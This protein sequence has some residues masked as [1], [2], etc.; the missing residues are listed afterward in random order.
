VPVSA[1]PPVPLPAQT[2][3]R[4]DSIPTF[5]RP[6]GSLLRPGTSTYQLTLTRPTGEA[7]SL[8]TLAVTVSEAQAGAMTGWLIADSRVGTLISTSDSVF[9]RRADLA[10]ERWTAVNG[11]AQLGVSFT[12]DSAFGALQNYQ[13]R[14]SFALGV[15]TNALLSTGMVQRVLELLPLAEGYRAGASLFV[16]E[17]LVPKLVPA[18][19]LVERSEGVPVGG[20]AEDA[21]RVVLRWGE[22]ERRLWIAR[23]GA[24]VVRTEQAV[25]EGVLTGVL[26]P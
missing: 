25:P 19:I 3:L 18:E 17:G 8:G 12:R 13:G 23:N 21:W 24:R 9:V 10:P 2:V 5:E 20:R 1:A 11:R 7:V 15:P 4:V 26:L 16:V 14:S 22:T 6:N